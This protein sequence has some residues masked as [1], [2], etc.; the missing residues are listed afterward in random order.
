MTI[1]NGVEVGYKFA[2]LF[3]L[4][5]ETEFKYTHSRSKTETQSVSN[6]ISKQLQES[7]TKKCGNSCPPND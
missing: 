1:S 4:A 3:G 7:I 5:G 2:H 6:A